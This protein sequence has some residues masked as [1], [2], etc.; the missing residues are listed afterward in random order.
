MRAKIIQESNSSTQSAPFNSNI[1]RLKVDVSPSS[2]TT[3]SLTGW[4]SSNDTNSQINLKFSSL[5]LAVQYAR[6]H[7][8]EYEIIK[9][10]PKKLAKKAYADNFK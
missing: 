10:S 3:D 4:S 8:L 2:I 1:W 5:D 9:L 6:N 7:A